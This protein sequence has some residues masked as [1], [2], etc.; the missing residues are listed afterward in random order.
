MATVEQR[1]RG[2]PR[3]KGVEIAVS[4]TPIDAAILDESRPPMIRSR[5][6]VK[7]VAPTTPTLQLPRAENTTSLPT[8][9]GDRTGFDGVPSSARSLVQGIA[10]VAGSVPGA[11]A[12]KS[13]AVLATICT[14]CTEYFREYEYRL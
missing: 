6:T 10:R 9:A 12:D 2:R 13:H 8:V 14:C 1:K 5:R 3:T 4:I 11:D 7:A